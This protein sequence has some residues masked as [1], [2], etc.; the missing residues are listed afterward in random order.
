MEEQPMPTLK[1]RYCRENLECS[2]GTTIAK[3]WNCGLTQSVPGSVNDDNA[4]QFLK[5]LDLRNEHL[6]DE[7]YGIYKD[8]NGK[9]EDDADLY[10]EL[11][12]CRLGIEYVKKPAEKEYL[13]VINRLSDVMVFD[14][15][16]YKKAM[17]LAIG[18]QKQL[19][20]RDA[21]AIYDVQKKMLAE[22]EGI[23][24]SDVFI[25]Y[26]TA[27]TDSF[28]ATDL[29]ELLGKNGYKVF[30]PESADTAKLDSKANSEPVIFEAI[31]TSKVMVVL[32]SQAESLTELG[33]AEMWRRYLGLINAGENREIVVAFRDMGEDDI[34]DELKGIT[35]TRFAGAENREEFLR[36]IKERFEVIKNRE[37]HKLEAEKAAQKAARAE[38]DK[39]LD[40]LMARIEEL[41]NSDVDYSEKDHNDYDRH[42]E[43]LLKHKK[44]Y[45]QA[46]SF[47]EYTKDDYDQLNEDYL[48]FKKR[49]EENPLNEQFKSIQKQI[50]EKAANIESNVYF[51]KNTKKQDRLELEELNEQRKFIQQRLD[52][53][54]E[55]LENKRKNVDMRKKQMLSAQ[56]NMLALQKTYERERSEIRSFDDIIKGKRKDALLMEAEKLKHS[57]GDTIEFGCWPN[58]KKIGWTIIASEGDNI[59]LL[60]TQVIDANKFHDKYEDTTWAGSYIRKFLNEE[61]YQKA[62]TEQEKR[63]ILLRPVKAYKNPLY[64]T[65]PGEDTEDKIFLLSVKEVR[66]YLE[67][68]DLVMAE[69]T[70]FAVSSGVEKDSKTGGC[71]WWLRTPGNAGCNVARVSGVGI[72]LEH[73]F[74]A[75]DNHN[76]IRPAMWIT[77]EV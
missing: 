49:T 26:N 37:E 41:D 71:Y 29:A 58:D 14:D 13:P 50:S 15:G 57:V 77:I 11:V 21:I 51:R 43:M 36:I 76:G 8:L 12:L 52:E 3:C 66:D 18:D 34:P 39:A 17:D 64:P 6:F 48:A 25:C 68:K 65:D 16:D 62:F 32:G 75:S 1:C 56:A 59:L 19:L 74:F 27:T 20:R 22:T 2:K 28:A 9:A 24:P 40:E 72:I 7:A 30:M 70:P 38:K 35:K 31:R 46:L 61:F 55:I 47:Y 73:G 4:E 63:R 67:E 42:L 10:W 69:P 54:A 53:D 60:S 33:T 5:A 23:E 45:E 44:R